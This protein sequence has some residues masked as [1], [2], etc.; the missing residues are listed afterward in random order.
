MSRRH[1]QGQRW[2]QLG[3]V[4]MDRVYGSVKVVQS[5]ARNVVERTDRLLAVPSKGKPR[6]REL[7]ERIGMVTLCPRVEPTLGVLLGAHRS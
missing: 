1:A 3:L 7:P 5:V 6:S 4:H 2:K